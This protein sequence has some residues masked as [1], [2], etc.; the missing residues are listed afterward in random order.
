VQNF[1]L[2]WMSNEEIVVISTFLR[3]GD[4]HLLAS[5]LIAHVSADTLALRASPSNKNRSCH[6]VWNLFG[7]SSL[8]VFLGTLFDGITRAEAR[9]FRYRDACNEAVRWICLPYASSILNTKPL[10][11][12]ILFHSSL[13]RILGKGRNINR[14]SIGCG[15]RHCLRIA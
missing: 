15:S 10:R 11:C 5:L 6:D 3:Q 14:L 12:T 13:H 2:L 1:A 4:F 7:G 8:E 9:I